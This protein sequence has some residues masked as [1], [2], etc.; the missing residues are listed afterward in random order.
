M[1]V[2]E[3]YEYLPFRT[4][5]PTVGNV[6][7]WCG[8]VINWQTRSADWN[9]TTSEIYKNRIQKFIK[10]FNFC[11]RE[12]NLKTY[13]VPA[14]KISIELDLQSKRLWQKSK[15]FWPT[16]DLLLH[17]E[18]GILASCTL[19]ILILARLVIAYSWRIKE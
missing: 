5:L 2:D 9:R 18:I 10:V 3:Q 15:D 17:I 1:G 14:H 16:S 6:E 11:M 8:S 13:I 7:K 4:A 19:I 12:T